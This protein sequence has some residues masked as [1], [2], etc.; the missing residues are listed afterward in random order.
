MLAHVVAH[1][2]VPKFHDGGGERRVAGGAGTV[3]GEEAERAVDDGES[4][5]FGSHKQERG[6]ATAWAPRRHKKF[7]KLLA[8]VSRAELRGVG[9]RPA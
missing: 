2:A 6:T 1:G 9:E 5:S 8:R 4:K 3:A 7:R